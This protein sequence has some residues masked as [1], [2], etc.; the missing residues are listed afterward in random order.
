MQRIVSK[1]LSDDLAEDKL[2]DILSQIEGIT[3]AGGDN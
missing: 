2:G 1:V 3:A